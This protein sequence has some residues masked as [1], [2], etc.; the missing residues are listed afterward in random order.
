MVNPVEVITA[1]PFTIRRRVNWG[2]C[3]PAGVVYTPRFSDFVVE[4][5]LSFSAHLFGSPLH[6]R[7]R[8]LDL[9][10]PAKA[11][12]MEFKQSLW[13]DQIFDIAVEVGGLRTRT[14]DLL[15]RATTPE[16]V[17]IFDAQFSPICVHHATR[18]SRTI[19]ADLRQ[20]LES[21]RESTRLASKTAPIIEEGEVP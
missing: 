19:P 4:A 21:Y 10:L 2:E 18:E 7:L 6:E 14:F 15:F 20:R 12:S 1:V 8:E 11:M 9:G 16:G 17:R 3:D 13:P 5:Y